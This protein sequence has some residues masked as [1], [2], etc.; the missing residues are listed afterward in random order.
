MGG[1]PTKELI[2]ERS[3]ILNAYFLPSSCEPGGLY[4]SITPVNSF[5][6]IF[7]SCFGA[8]LEL[9]KDQSYWSMAEQPFDFNLVDDLLGSK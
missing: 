2:E 3:G 9:L 5:R 1:T 6:V 8:D 4:R 7:N